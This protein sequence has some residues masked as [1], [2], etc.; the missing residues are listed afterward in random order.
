MGKK[1]TLREITYILI[2]LAAIIVL[3]YWYTTQNSRRMEERNKNYAADS[4]R[5]T[6][7]KIDDKLS[8]AEDLITTYAYFIQKTLTAPEITVEMLQQIEEKSLF[9]TLIFTD[10]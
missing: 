9:D 1:K 5:L 4:A 6:A 2:L 3:F 7:V 8:T 10:R